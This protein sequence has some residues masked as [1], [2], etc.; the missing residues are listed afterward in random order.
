[1][2]AQG[3]DG[4]SRGYLGQGVMAGESMVAHIPIHI[5]AV[6]R[7]T[8]LVPWIRSWCGDDAVLL[9]E[10]GGLKQ[11]TVSKDGKREGTGSRP[12]LA[13]GRDIHLVSPIAAEVALAELRKARIKR[14]TDCHI[15]VCP[16]CVQH[17]GQS[18]F[19]ERQTSCLNCLLVPLA[20]L[21][22][23][24]T[25]KCSQ[26]VGSCG[27][28]SRNLK[29]AHGIFCAN[30]GHSVVTSRPCQS[31]WCGSCYSFDESVKF[32]VATGDLPQA[33]NGDEDRLLS[34]WLPK[35]SDAGKFCRARDGDDLLVSFE[36]DTCIFHKLYERP[37]NNQNSKDMFSLACIR[38]VNL[39]AFWSRATDTVKQN[40]RKV[41]E[42][43][44]ISEQLGL[45]G[46]YLAPG[47]LPAHDHCGYEVALQIVVSSREGGRYATDHKQWDT[48]RRFRTCYSN[49]IRAARDA[50]SSPLV[51]AD[52]KGSGYQ[53]LAIDPCGSLWFQRF[54]LGCC[55]RMGQDWR[56]NQA[57]GIQIVHLLLQ[58]VEERARA[59][60][61]VEERHTWVMAGGYYCICFVLS[62]RSPEG[63]MADLEGLLRFHDPASDEVVVP[64]LGRFKGEHHAK[65]HLLIS[66]ATTGSGIEVKLWLS[67]VIAVHKAKGRSTGPAFVDPHGYQSSTADMNALFLDVLTDI[68]EDHP[69]LFGRDIVDAS[70]LVDKYNVFRSFRRG[71][72][73][74]AVAMKVSE[75]DRYVVNRWKKK[76]AAGT[77]KV[78]HAIDQHY[79]DVNMVK[80]SF[81]RYTNAM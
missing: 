31:T 54:M 30:F 75:A 76:E 50:N 60:P 41:R 62:L 12:K 42:G 27:K 37:P 18:N 7:S 64:L 32:F 57:I 13:K 63:L 5:S 22:I 70:T 56:P 21:V 16:D 47:P 10:K 40:T 78:S 4:V 77:G 17:N 28:C 29:W 39:D 35:K 59:A 71:S 69:H 15:I 36:C 55:R 23:K 46:P 52:N 26:W 53:R 66:C 74:R 79:V 61:T 81:I 25:P 2:I 3:T 38:R 67:R 24:G 9:D 58:R 6:D 14:Q 19:T 44:K 49:Q 51:L 8:N 1:M 48:V 43:L 72:E 68:Y 65:Q 80:D 11:G 33:G 20:G 45:S 34:G 73:S